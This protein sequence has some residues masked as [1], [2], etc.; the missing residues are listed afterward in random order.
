MYLLPIPAAD[1]GSC[2]HRMVIGYVVPDRLQSG[3]PSGCRR[4]GRGSR[5]RKS[6]RDD[7]VQIAEASSIAGIQ[8]KPVAQSYLAAIAEDILSQLS[9]SVLVFK[10]AFLD[11]SP[12]F[13]HTSAYLCGVPHFVLARISIALRRNFQ[14]CARLAVVLF[15]HTVASASSLERI[16]HYVGH[17]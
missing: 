4:M 12:A 15:N 2:H 13:T 17:Y 1:N 10:S 14:R 9:K 11:A 5:T 3:T 6:A 8:R 7:L 16:S